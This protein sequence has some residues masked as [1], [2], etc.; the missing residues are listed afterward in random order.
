M[1]TNRTDFWGITFDTPN[2]AYFNPT[3]LLKELRNVEVLELSSVDTSEVIY[4]FR[5]TIP[6]FS[7]LFRLT[8]I[9]DS[10]GYGW[11]VLPVLLKNSPNLQTLV[12]KGPLYAEKLRREYGWT[13]PVKVLKITEYG[14]K[15]E[16]LEQM[17]RFL[18]KLSYVELVKV[19]AC[20]INDKEKTRVTKDLLMVPRSSKC[21]IQI[22]F[23]DNT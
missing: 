15:L 11:Q 16:E 14:G 18:K 1:R 10:L 8:I 5:E 13:C 20:A 17:K 19:R 23:I 9:T 3:N 6:V 7:N 21:K 12:I 4:Y 2:L 22:K